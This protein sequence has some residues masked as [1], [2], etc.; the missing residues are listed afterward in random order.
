[1]ADK[2]KPAIRVS[3]RNFMTNRLLC[4]KQF[5]CEV[6]HPGRGTVHKKELQ[7]KIAQMF[8]IQEENTIVLFGF[9]TQFGGGK[10]KGFGL[11]YDNLAFCKRYEPKYRLIRLGLATKKEGSRKQ[12]K[13]K[14]NRLKKLRGT[15]K[16][17]GVSKK[18]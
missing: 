12:R 10:S 16:V 3:L 14:K 9:K 2:S 1:M 4:R 17:K 6:E 8:K 11:I 7:A 15:A 13:E 18:K 5:V